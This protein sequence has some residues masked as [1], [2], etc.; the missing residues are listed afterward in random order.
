MV[1][2]HCVP[3]Q[4]DASAPIATRF[5]IAGG[6]VHDR[7]LSAIAALGGVQLR[8]VANRDAGASQNASSEK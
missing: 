3:V 5:T 7:T 8:G 1:A 4:I 2:W 6:T